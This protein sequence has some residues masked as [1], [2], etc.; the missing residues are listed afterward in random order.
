MATDAELDQESGSTKGLIQV[1]IL[2][3]VLMGAIWQLLSQ[4]VDTFETNLQASLEARSRIHE[5]MNK[6]LDEK[7]DS[8]DT[9]QQR[10]LDAIRT[11]LDDYEREIVASR[12]KLVTLDTKLIEVET[13]FRGVREVLQLTNAS[14]DQRVEALEEKVLERLEWRPE[15]RPK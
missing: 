8:R 10:Q 2:L 5:L 4:R 9:A 12:E 6:A 3:L 13:Q 15:S 14:Q 1:A 7:S 11:R